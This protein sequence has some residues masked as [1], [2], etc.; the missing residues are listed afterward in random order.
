MKGKIIT[1]VALAAVSAFTLAGCKNDDSTGGVLKMNLAY[2]D[3]KKTLTYDMSSPITMPDGTV[4][5][6]G[7][8]K[9]MWQYVE[10]QLNIDIQDVTVQ[11][12]K[13]SEMITVNAANQF[14]DA[15]IFGGNSV[16]DDLMAHGANGLFIEL[17]EHLDEM[18]NLKKY[19]DANPNVKSAITA[20][21]GHIYHLPYVA[22]I[23]NYA[24]LYHVRQS[25][26]TNLLDA[27]KPNYD[28]TAVGQTYV[29]PYYTSA[30]PRAK[31]I[32]GRPTKKT[33]EN[34]IEI[35]NALEVKNGQT[36]TEAL[37][38]Y[39]KRNYS[40]TNPSELYLGNDA[41]YD[42][43]ELVALF[44]CVEAN[45]VYL[46]GK[47]DGETYAWFT[48]QPAYREEIL[49]FSTYYNGTK[50]HG[51]DAYSSR[52]AYNSE[53]QVEY[54]Y[55]TEEMYNNLL[56]FQ[57]WNKEGLIYGDSLSDGD[58]KT[59]L[60][61][62][63][64]GSDDV[65]EQKQFGFM[66][67]DF[68]AST[69]SDSLNDDVVAI[70]PPVANVNGVWQQY[71]D[72]GRVIKSDGWAISSKASSSSQAQAFKVFDYFFTE[73]GNILTNYGLPD[74]IDSTGSFTGPDG[75]TYPKYTNWIKEQSA[76]FTKGDYSN[77]LRQ[78]I[79]CQ[80]PIGYQKEIGFEYQYT[81]ERG[82]AATKLYT[83]EHVGMPTYAGTGATTTG[84]NPN[85][86]RLVPPA[87]SLN[88]NQ[89]SQV[90]KLN[91]ATDTGFIEPM[92]NIIRGLNPSQV[93]VPQSYAEYLKYFNDGG[94]ATYQKI[95]QDAYKVMAG[96]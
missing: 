66:C 22:E 96:L 70:L 95:Y 20:Y 54:T 35:Q 30:N 83:D 49:R 16:A 94:L 60:R 58:S 15:T 14:A 7:D 8:L 52:W 47:T 10:K 18:P 87:F 92:F 13:A 77:F 56:R 71:V 81:S 11:S 73:E 62:K 53:G 55:A 25:W 1:S 59:D 79:G 26:V 75:I 42:M 34:I 63:L 64:Y 28:T 88:K 84:S 61:A 82:L 45:P 78:V 29:E 39:I 72:N 76:I 4:V 57:A 48:R 43:D 86:Y 51:S 89:S 68:T 65:A 5:S 80:M 36:Y 74:M 93:T 31:E 24:R 2:G 17:D 12:Q 21:D 50:V 23:G 44:R 19:L 6:S 40:Y 33:D 69:T 3:T 85:Y 32:E 9:P 90:S 41:A 46:T 91:I 27:Q 67:Y 38:S 37:I